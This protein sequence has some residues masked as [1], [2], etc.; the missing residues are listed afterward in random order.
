[1]AI[2]HAGFE[3]GS[4][5]FGSQLMCVILFYTSTIYVL[6]LFYPYFLTAIYSG[7]NLFD[8]Y[9]SMIAALLA[10]SGSAKSKS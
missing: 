7:K 6:N 1:M 5:K 3:I 10:E 9:F 4:M 2:M 8:L